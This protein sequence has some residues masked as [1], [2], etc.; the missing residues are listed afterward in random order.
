MKKSHWSVLACLLVC[1][2][3]ASLVFLDP[4]DGNQVPPDKSLPG[5]NETFVDSAPHAELPFSGPSR[6][7]A[8][9]VPEG[10]PAINIEEILAG[11]RPPV[12]LTD[13]PPEHKPAPEW[14]AWKA[15]YR[16]LD[17][18]SRNSIAPVERLRGLQSSEADA[19]LQAGYDYQQQLAS[20]EDEAHSEI[21]ARF[22]LPVNAPPLPAGVDP[23]RVIHL[24]YGVTLREILEPEGF[25]ERFDARKQSLLNSHREYLEQLIG[26][27]QFKWLDNH[28][29]TA[30]APSIKVVTKAR[31][32]P[33]EEWPASLR[34]RAAALRKAAELGYGPADLRNLD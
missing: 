6:I 17:S 5:D 18:L 23:S 29:K 27:A 25:Y 14:S 32:L 34:D 21:R 12:P 11:V 19:V 20:I 28:V 8:D 30:I 16:S 7:N 15:L 10:L 33:P 31:R 13:G 22:P 9:T 24:P 4:N 1:V 26:P 2:A 3:V